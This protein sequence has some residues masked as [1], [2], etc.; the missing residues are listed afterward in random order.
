MRL[1]RLL[2][3]VIK[4]LNRDKISAQELAGDFEV[5]VRTIY[6]DVEAINLAG[7]PII[8]FQGQ[9][10]G[11]G[12]IEN[13]KLDK[14]VF[15]LQDITAIL[16]VLKGFQATFPDKKIDIA[17]EKIRNLVPKEK[18]KELND[19]HD[20]VVIDMLPWGSSQKQKRHLKLVQEAVSQKKLIKFMYRN[21][22]GEHGSR[23]VEPMTL[24]F[25]MYVWYLYG[26]CRLKKDYRFFRLTRMD[27]V[28]PLPE[29]FIRRQQ[30][31]HEFE[32]A[33]N[34]TTKHKM[35]SL[36]L[37]FSPR[38]RYRVEDI[39]DIEKVTVQKDGAT[40]VRVTWPDDQG[41]YMFLLGFGED[42][43][44][45]RPQSVRGILHAKAKKIVSKYSAS[46]RSDVKTEI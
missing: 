25:K 35:V 31:F 43:Q 45:I 2:A 16:S 29:K 4:L 8:S 10:G 24:I 30:S 23:V 26:Y 21:A 20:Q 32:Q 39:F 38:L 18:I 40:I 5:S 22:K 36:V 37:N 46:F 11:F 42:L 34:K 28:K 12:I 44:V 15:T 3:I 41:L 19:Q 13:F 17:A 27:K 1:D 9:Q 7:I 14:Q 33:V 6:R